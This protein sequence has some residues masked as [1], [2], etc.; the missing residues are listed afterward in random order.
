MGFF[1]E[2]GA[3][4]IAAVADWI[5]SEYPDATA[6]DEA[7]LSAQ[8]AP[9]ARAGWRIRLTDTTFGILL[10]GRDFPYEI[11]TVVIEGA[12]YQRAPHVEANQRLCLDGDEARANTRDPVGLAD[13]VIQRARALVRGNEAGD[14]ASDYQADFRPYWN[15]SAVREPGVQTL[16]RMDPG[17]REVRAWEGNGI[18]LL[19]D[20]DETAS[21]WLKHRFGDQHRTMMPALLAWLDPLPAPTEYPETVN[22]LRRLAPDIQSR[23]DTLLA[24][25]RNKLFVALRG[26]TSDGR[27]HGGVIRLDLNRPS[28]WTGK[29]Q[30]GGFR[31]GKSP[32]PELNACRWRTTRLR[33][34]PVDVSLSRRPE[35]LTGLPDKRVTII[36]CGAVGSGVAR[37]LV[38]SGLGRLRL[39]DPELLGH[40]NIGR[41]ELGSAE[42][43][44]SKARALAERLRKAFPTVHDILPL[45]A[46]WLGVLHKD[47][48]GLF[49]DDDL[50]IAATGDWNSEGALSDLHRRRKFSAPILYGWLE[51]NASAAHAVAIAAHGPHCFRCGF[52]PL[53]NLLTP[54]TRWSGP[55]LI[56]GCAAPTSPFG[57]IEL[58]HAQALIAELAVDLL[59]GS[60]DPGV[61][62]VWYGRKATITAQGGRWNRNWIMAHGDPGEGARIAPAPWPNREPCPHD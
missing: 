2:A 58:G 1:D 10:L 61:R 41:H 40:E 53:G 29:R 24:D 59:T 19:A 28:G 15:R 18:T 8:Q 31:P 51:Q 45:E 20:D 47:G 33:E 17:T 55:P 7:A 48:E 9:T 46:D 32:A 21:R 23:L 22:D 49:D 57:A 25:G 12:Q 60:A 16:L 27:V 26:P 35:N 5:A 4:A 34:A 11:P 56:D 30:R 14:H 62:W 38:Q 6:V 44:L 50:V 43:G 42:V 13:H 36:G 37:L 52:D 39:I 54:V 3:V